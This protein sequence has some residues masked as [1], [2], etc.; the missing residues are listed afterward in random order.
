MSSVNFPVGQS[1]TQ[2]VLL[3]KEELIANLKSIKTQR[4]DL[5]H[6]NAHI[7]LSHD[8]VL[9]EMLIEGVPRRRLYRLESPG[10]SSLALS[11]KYVCNPLRY[12]IGYDATQQVADWLIDGMHNLAPWSTWWKSNL[13]KLLSICLYT[14][15]RQDISLGQ[16]SIVIGHKSRA[17]S[18]LAETLQQSPWGLSDVE[19]NTYIHAHR[20]LSELERAM[21]GGLLGALDNWAR[22]L[23][24]HP[25]VP[26]NNDSNGLVFVLQPNRQDSALGP[27]MHATWQTLLMELM[28]QRQGAPVTLWV[29]SINDFPVPGLEA[30]IQKPSLQLIALDN[31]RTIERIYGTE[32]GTRIWRQIG[33][34]TES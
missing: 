12:C 34:V 19:Q 28:R 10:G 6:G 23:E 15:N 16:W 14:H 11:S 18:L 26:V 9:T 4:I 31:R 3:S 13:S 8:P 22:G 20:N 24:P 2:S 33:L 27:W 21:L 17:A 25:E 5:S 30:L 29:D 32:R 7:I 1:L